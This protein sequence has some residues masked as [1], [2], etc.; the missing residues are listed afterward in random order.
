MDSHIHISALGLTAET[1]LFEFAS[2]GVN[3]HVVFHLL[4]L[5]EYQILHK[6]SCILD[7]SQQSI[8]E[9]LLNLLV[10]SF[11]WIRT[12]QPPVCLRGDDEF[13]KP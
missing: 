6:L 5:N 9:D 12:S 3:T 1:R 4:L 13:E 2:E 7:P 8:I 10:L 11:D